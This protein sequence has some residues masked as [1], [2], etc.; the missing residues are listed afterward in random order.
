MPIKIDATNKL[1]IVGILSNAD[2]EFVSMVSHAANWRPFTTIKAEVPNMAGQRVHAIV[3]PLDNAE[4]ILSDLSGLDIEQL[5]ELVG[6][7]EF[8]GIKTE[9]VTKFDTTIRYIQKAETEFREDCAFVVKDI[10]Q[11]G[12]QV[13]LGELRSKGDWIPDA[14]DTVVA[15]VP[16]PPVQVSFADAFYQQIDAFYAVVQ[17][18]FTLQQD[19]TKRKS[20][21]RAAWQSVS[22]WL[23]TTL[24][25][26]S[27][28]T[29]KFE[30]PDPIAD[31]ASEIK[32]L[33]TEL[34]S[35][36]DTTGGIDTMFAS[37]DELKTFIIDIINETVQAKTEDTVAE[38]ETVDTSKTDELQ[39]TLT[40]IAEKLQT[41]ETSVQALSE[42]TEALEHT[43]DK[44]RSADEDY[45]ATKTDSK[46]K[47]GSLFSVKKAS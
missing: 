26:V 28:D 25:T 22:D 1:D 6:D 43:P 46:S 17:G 23:N 34:T 8:D 21:I 9:T 45:T 19:A 5:R 33:K 44:S 10:G 31:L 16:V 47:F 14:M 11:T 7:A 12:A 15:E 41:L 27:Q 13:V 39:S 35:V 3:M 29:L 40:S 24:D 32:A 38:T 42:K 20:T 37:K 2:V 30:R 18:A 36:Q 4:Q